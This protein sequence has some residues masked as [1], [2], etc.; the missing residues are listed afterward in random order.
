MTTT[1]PSI[2]IADDHP[3]VRTGLREIIETRSGFRIVAECENG[4]DA[5]DRI[6][7]LRPDIA[8]LDIE[9]PRLSGI[10]VA[11]VVNR[12]RLPIRMIILTITNSVELFNQAME[13]GVTG[14][15][16]KDSAVSD[17]KAAIREVLAGRYFCSPSLVGQAQPLSRGNGQPYVWEEESTKLMRMER[18]I[19]RLI[20]ENRS[21]N[22][23]AALLSISRRTVDSH[24]EH[25]TRKLG[26]HGCYALLRYALQHREHL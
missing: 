11:A 16:L 5:L 4:A 23:I 14:Y 26:L 9:M 13:Y 15:V 12:D 20:G 19:L 1:A 25:L 18:T 21:T 3:I 17:L 10:D 6:R 24:R 8:I 2:L 22:E 7:K